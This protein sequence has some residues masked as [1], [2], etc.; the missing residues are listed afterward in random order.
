MTPRNGVSAVEAEK[1]CTVLRIGKCL[2][3]HMIVGLGKRMLS[4][5]GET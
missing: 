4:P 1:Y 5:N 3:P 2:E